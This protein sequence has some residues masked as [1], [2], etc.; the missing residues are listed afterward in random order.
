MNF[1]YEQFTLITLEK[2]F[3]P[4]GDPDLNSGPGETFFS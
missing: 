4:A 2:K 3:S 1:I